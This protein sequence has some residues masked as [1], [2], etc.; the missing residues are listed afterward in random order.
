MREALHRIGLPED[1]YVCAEKP[2]IPLAQEL[3]VIC[4]LTIATW[5]TGHGQVGAQFR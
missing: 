1:R 2:S 5:R 4:D 3:M